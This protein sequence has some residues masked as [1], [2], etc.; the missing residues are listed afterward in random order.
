MNQL[1]AKPQ[2]LKQA[3]LSHIRKVIRDRGDATRAEIA[4]VT[5]ISITTVRTLLTELLQQREIE[6]VGHDR[7]S[8]GRKAERYRLRPDRYHCAAL[9]MND[10]A[11]DA[12]VVNACGEIVQTTRLSVEQGEWEQAVFAFLDRLTAQLEIRAI[13]MGV[14]GIVEED[15]YWRKQPGGEMMHRVEIGK[16]LTERYGLPVVLE[17]D[18]NAT[19]IGFGRC[20]QQQFPQAGAEQT[21]MAYLYFEESC[22]SAGFVVGGQ[23]VRGSSNFAG[24]LGLVPMADGQ[25]LDSLFARP[26]DDKSY[27]RLAVQV[28]GW[29]C[30]ILN[31]RYVALGG[32]ALR[33]HCIAPIADGLSALLP[34]RMMTELLSAPDL[35]HDYHS[36]MAW[37][38]AGRMFEDV[39]LIKGQVTV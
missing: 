30:G 9:C 36:G 23:V 18:L 33:N 15:G 32:P 37:L 35:W 3:N 12:L 29:V 6:S 21:N 2:L 20:Y 10:Q 17:N 25:P 13:G 22:I 34:R 28:I 24:E 11:L 39:R 16:A 27:V 19:A 31:P 5:D 38:T 26:M 14:P 7:S 1:N 4:A 8:G